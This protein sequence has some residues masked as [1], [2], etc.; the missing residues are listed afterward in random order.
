M[1]PLDMF[2][3]KIK[4]RNGTKTKDRR[5]RVKEVIKNLDNE[6]YWNSAVDAFAD[7]LAQALVVRKTD[8]LEEKE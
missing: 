7:R 2:D 5:E 8:D 1:T 4:P 6:D 3:K